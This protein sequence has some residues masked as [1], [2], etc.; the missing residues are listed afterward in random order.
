MTEASISQK[1]ESVRGSFGCTISESSSGS[2]WTARHSSEGR[3]PTNV[4]EKREKK[5]MNSCWWKNDH[6]LIMYPKRSIGTGAYEVSF[7]GASASRSSQRK[8]PTPGCSHFTRFWKAN[9]L[10]SD[11]QATTTKTAAGDSNG[12]RCRAGRGASQTPPQLASWAEFHKLTIKRQTVHPFQL[13]K[14]I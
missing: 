13:G 1:S 6:F 5:R 3:R 12:T 10:A 8:A 14:G 11:V 4:Q 9:E 2:R 7:A